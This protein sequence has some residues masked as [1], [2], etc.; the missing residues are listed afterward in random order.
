M[1]KKVIVGLVVDL[2]IILVVLFA[3]II[4]KNNS[5]CTHD[6]ESQIVVL[7]AVAPT[8]QKTGL[9][10]GKKCNSCGE[11]IEEQQEVAKI[12]C[13]ES[14][15]II[16]REATHTEDGKYHTQCTMCAKIMFNG[17]LE[18]GQKKYIYGVFSDGTYSIAAMGNCQ[19]SDIIIPAEYN[20]KAVISIGFSAFKE[21]TQLTSIVI[22]TSVTTIGAN[23]FYECKELKKIEY[24]GTMEQWNS[25]RK[26]NDWCYNVGC[27]VVICTD[28]EVTI[29]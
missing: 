15:W 16:D 19:E 20:G 2:L 8:C 4:I 12:E 3:I 21:S 22:P 13:I 9:T 18:S 6:D 1:K 7:D 10:E 28:G 11:I 25:I 17:V 5:E 27:E 14:N 24:L 29:K 23:A 26:G